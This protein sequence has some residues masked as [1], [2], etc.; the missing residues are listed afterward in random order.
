MADTARGKKVDIEVPDH[1]QAL[2]F[3][4]RRRE[5][6]DQ[7]QVKTENCVTMLGFTEKYRIACLWKTLWIR[8][9]VSSWS[10]GNRTFGARGEHWGCP[11]KQLAFI[12][13]GA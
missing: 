5:L 7:L 4:W 1:P 6:I 13:I 2:G 8:N 9:G 12:Q 3:G 11:K 10:W